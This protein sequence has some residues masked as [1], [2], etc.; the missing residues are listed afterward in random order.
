MEKKV[1]VTQ[2]NLKSGNLPRRGSGTKAD[3]RSQYNLDLNLNSRSLL[4]GE[5][6]A[7]QAVPKDGKRTVNHVSLWL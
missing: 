4:L 2:R 3:L 1:I 7:V 6:Q 5:L